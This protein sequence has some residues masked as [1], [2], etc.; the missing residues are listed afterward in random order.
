MVSSGEH[1][2]I[3]EN[4]L[5][6][7]L[8]PISIDI[9]LTIVTSH[10]S[11]SSAMTEHR[12]LMQELYNQILTITDSFI[13][14]TEQDISLNRQSNLLRLRSAET[15]ATS[16]FSISLTTDRQLTQALTIINNTD[17]LDIQTYEVVYDEAT[18]SDE[19]L[20]VQLTD[21]MLVDIQNEISKSGETLTPRGFKRLDIETEEIGRDFL[22]ALIDGQSVPYWDQSDQGI[23]LIKMSKKI[24]VGLILS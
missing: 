24:S 22:D 2:R 20:I 7:V 19:A 1:D 5:D 13:Q 15:L 17:S 10:E 6:V 8:A 23:T 16:H 4:Q 11:E 9:S 12:Q 14:D 3:L 18:T 21:K